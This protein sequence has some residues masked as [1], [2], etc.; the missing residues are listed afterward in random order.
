VISYDLYGRGLSARPTG[1]HD[2]RLYLDQLTSLMDHLELVKPVDLIGY[3][4]GGA[5]AQLAAARLPDRIARITL[6][7]SAGAGTTASLFY[8]FCADM[9]VLGDGLW[10]WRAPA[11][12]QN[13]TAPTSTM[14]DMRTIL[15]NDAAILG[16]RAAWLSSL[17]H[18]LREDLAPDRYVIAA[19]QIPVTAIWGK[20]DPIIPPSAAERV[21]RDIP[22]TQTI[23]LHD[24]D[25][26]LA[27]THPE[28]ILASL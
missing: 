7:A 17:R 21:A 11:V 22:Y 19:Q 14:P 12:M 13:S 15:A 3:S 9:P 6:L 1:R 2:A 24:A 4:M 16:T 5:I 23:H 10:A 20:R 25:H 26:A 18:L 27:H 28:A 8:R